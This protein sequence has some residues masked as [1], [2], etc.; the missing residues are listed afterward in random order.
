MPRW[1][2][3]PK[4]ASTAEVSEAAGVNRVTL[5]R[6]VN[7]GILPAPTKLSDGISGVHNRWPAWAIERAR[8]VRRR[9]DEML[10]LP[11][12]A[13]LVEAGEAPGPLD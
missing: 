8:W 12:V 11:E 7:M 1:R 6:W 2:S 13:A 9:R 4:Y 10:T 5:W 3:N